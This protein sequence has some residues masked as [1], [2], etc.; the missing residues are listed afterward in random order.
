MV[1]DY[2][3]G[4]NIRVASVF[5]AEQQIEKHQTGGAY[6]EL[7]NH[8][9]SLWICVTEDLQRANKVPLT[10][11]THRLGIDLVD[12]RRRVSLASPGRRQCYLG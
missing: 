7:R 4:H 6:G 12:R 11:A 3:E 5:L 2:L 10:R 9:L 8:I 1:A